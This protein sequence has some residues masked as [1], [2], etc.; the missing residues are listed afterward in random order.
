MKIAL[1]AAAL[2]VAATVTLWSAP[3]DACGCF[4]PPDPT[5]PVVQA[6][7]RIIFATENGE[8]T[9]HIQ[10]SYDGPAAEFGWLLPLPSVPDLQLGSDEVFNV[11]TAQTQPKY[12]LN[13]VYEGN[14]TFDP[15]RIL[16]AAN[17]GAPEADSGAAG[18][19]GS[20]S[21]LVIQDSVGPYDYAVLKADNKDE[22]LKWLNDNR[23][24]IPVGTQDA[25]GPYIRPGAYFLA[26][27][28]KSGKSTGDLQPVVL[29][30]QSDLPMIPLV[31]TSVAAKPDMGIQVWMLG[32]GRAIPR[33]YYHTVINDALIDWNTGGAN[34][35]DVIIAATKEAPDHHTFVTEYA[36]TSSIMDGLLDYP[37]RFGSEAELAAMPDAVSFVE[38]LW[39]HN[40][41]IQSQGQQAFFTQP[42]F[43]ATLDAILGRYIPVPQ[44]MLDQGY[45]AS[46]FYSNIRYFLGDFRA[47]NPQLF[48]NYS[49]D[50][51]PAEMAQE[52][53]E[54]V[55][56]PAREASKLFAE[57]PYL[58]RLYT[59]ISPDDMN[60]DP[61]FSFNPSLP[62][63]SNVHEATL[64]YHCGS[65][66]SDQTHTPATLVTESGYAQIF[67]GGF[68][69]G[70]FQPPNLPASLRVEILREEGAPETI[71]NNVDVILRKAGGCTTAGL[72]L[73]GAAALVA[74][75]GLVR[76]ARRR[77]K[78]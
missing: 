27:K 68:G 31:L 3:V 35:N 63:W 9:A 20:A 76:S 7:E 64:T 13:R 45:T 71:I 17:A 53:F 1:S 65:Y 69:G 58:T 46:G 77:A 42:A 74:L 18:G 32:E 54:R 70:T 23:Y 4:A 39:A 40:F 61:V 41:Q 19:S 49:I 16:R 60:K 73:S 57:H 2:A 6:G 43:P 21:P 33:N 47:R 52:I 10:I 5:V 24:F 37:G 25:V 67:N 78:K 50:Y 59:T 72:E 38:Y 55:V 28:L 66:A 11:V 56:T 14:C 51:R 15:S 30:Y 29:R 75:A 48:V 44:G 22:M 12:R 62:D 26:L 34:Y 36:G 8:V